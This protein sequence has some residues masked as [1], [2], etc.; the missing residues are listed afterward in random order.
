M[1]VLL[2]CAGILT[3]AVW[4]IINFLLTIKLL[5][6]AILQRSKSKLSALL[7]IKFPLLYLLGFL[8][9]TA[10]AFPAVSLFLGLGLALLIIGVKGLW[11][12][13]S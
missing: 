1:Q 11:R 10:R 8:L 7:L 4:L 9:L 3:G 13:R 12:K 6:V 5:K 2:F